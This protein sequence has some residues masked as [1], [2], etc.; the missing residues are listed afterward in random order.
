MHTAQRHLLPQTLLCTAL[1]ANLLP[2]CRRDLI[3]SVQLDRRMGL[4]SF[5]SRAPPKVLRRYGC[6]TKCGRQDPLTKS[7]RD[8]E[9]ELWLDPTA[10]QAALQQRQQHC[11]SCMFTA[12][13]L[14]GG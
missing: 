1:P 8:P 3:R 13:G 4:L 5:T 7:D 12:P 11:M 9:W 2:S 14:M 6:C 10:P